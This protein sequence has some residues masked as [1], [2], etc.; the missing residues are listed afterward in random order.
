MCDKYDVLWKR[1][2][3]EKKQ[4][5][6]KQFSEAE[7]HGVAFDQNMMCVCDLCNGE[8]KLPKHFDLDHIVPLWSDGTNELS[9][10]QAICPN[11]HRKKTSIERREYYG[12]GRRKRYETMKTIR[13]FHNTKELPYVDQFLKHLRAGNVDFISKYFPKKGAIVQI[14]E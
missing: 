13:I 14:D 11:G 3:A 4:F 10:L 12:K 8:K 2:V 6:R 7:K 5:I 1:F 9:N